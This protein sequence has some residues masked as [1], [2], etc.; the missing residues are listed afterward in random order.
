MGDE[1][2]ET[3][4]AVAVARRQSAEAMALSARVWRRLP[5]GGGDSPEGGWARTNGRQEV[6]DVELKR[7]EA[8]ARASQT[9]ES[10]DALAAYED[11]DGRIVSEAAGSA[12]ELRKWRASLSGPEAERPLE[13]NEQQREVVGRVVNRMIEECAEDDTGR[14]RDE[15]LLW[16]LH[17]G[18]GTGKSYVVDALRKHVFEGIM[19]WRHG[20]DFQVAALQATN[21]SALDGHTLH[22]A[23][24]TTPF[25]SGSEKSKKG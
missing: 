25:A 6:S 12:R 2:P 20:L 22:A 16:I 4:A 7:R 10:G 21:A 13:L 15:P 19:K 18:P 8:E 9:K 24:G 3:P 11:E 5:G 23:F 17:G 14:V 1:S